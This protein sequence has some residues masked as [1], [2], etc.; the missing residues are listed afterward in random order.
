M[1]INTRNFFLYLLCV[2]FLV[3]AIVTTISKSDNGERVSQNS[4]AFI[5]TDISEY[6]VEIS[7]KE[8]IDREANLISLRNKI[9]SSDKSQ[10]ISA[11]KTVS[12][13]VKEEVVLTSGKKAGEDKC[14]GYESPKSFS[15][16]PGV[17]FE[18]VEGARI[19]YRE[20]PVV[21][22]STTTQTSEYEK[23]VF[24]QLPL[25]TFPMTVQ[26][27]L[28]Y[29]VVG[30]ALDGSP[31]RN[32]EVGVYSIFGSDTLIGYALDGFSI[33]G[34]NDNVKL[35][36]CGGAT[37]GGQYRYYLAKDASVILNCFSG[38]PIKI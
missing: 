21:S 13:E 18:V 7:E 20:V 27:C 8:K 14:S 28:P 6:G 29:D 19:A 23:E 36:A 12:E 31:I 5:T 37:V 38:V 2:G 32:N 1:L 17:E 25:R 3:I 16:P 35:D 4:P 30:V 24:L 26:N 10:F 33:Y 34:K 22:F 15:I 9:A 11:P